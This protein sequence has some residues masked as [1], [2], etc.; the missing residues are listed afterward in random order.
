M[1]YLAKKT[2][3]YLQDSAFI[4]LNSETYTNKWNVL[5]KSRF[6]FR[7]IVRLLVLIVR[8][9]LINGISCKKVDFFFAS[10]CIY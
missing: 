10:F 9:I 3:S 8:H 1:E 7:K 4:S 2:F 5:Q 6:P